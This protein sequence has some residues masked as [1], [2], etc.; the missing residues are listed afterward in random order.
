MGA[1][2]E[3]HWPRFRRSRER[4]S[5]LTLAFQEGCDGR[6]ARASSRK[7]ESGEG[8]MRKGAKLKGIWAPAPPTKS[9]E[10][11]SLAL[12]GW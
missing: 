9:E 3:A 8:A 1:A 11:A 6:R 2:D 7:K 12:Q 4:R 5:G 10:Q